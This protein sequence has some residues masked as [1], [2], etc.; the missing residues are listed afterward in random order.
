MSSE[1]FSYK[2]YLAHKDG[3][4][5]YPIRIKNRE[6]GNIAFRISEGGKGGNTKEAGLEVTDEEQVKDYVLN[7]GFAVRVSTVDKN[8]KGLYKVGH[9]SILKAVV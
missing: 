7:K 4:K 2:F 6:S 8:I 5:L 1:L 9:R 3:H